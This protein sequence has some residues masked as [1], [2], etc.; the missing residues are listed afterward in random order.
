M[1]INPKGKRQDYASHRFS[2]SNYR[3]WFWL[4]LHPAFGGKFLKTIDPSTG[5]DK[6]IGEWKVKLYLDGEL[7]TTKDFFVAC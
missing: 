4:K 3:V 1:W 6:F 2:D 5:M 7:V